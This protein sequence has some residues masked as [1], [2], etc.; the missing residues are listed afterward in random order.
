MMEKELVV[1]INGAGTNGMELK[2]LQK[3]L[4]PVP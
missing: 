3:V 1:I 2:A 4:S